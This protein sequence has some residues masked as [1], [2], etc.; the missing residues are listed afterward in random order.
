METHRTAS[1]TAPKRRAQNSWEGLLFFASLNWYIENA[2]KNLFTWFL[3]LFENGGMQGKTKFVYLLTIIDAYCK[4]IR[5]FHTSMEFPP[6][7]IPPICIVPI[8]SSTLTYLPAKVKLPSLV[9]LFLV[10]KVSSRLTENLAKFKYSEKEKTLTLSCPCCVIYLW[11]SKTTGRSTAS[12]CPIKFII[13]NIQ[14]VDPS[15]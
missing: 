7:T 2:I 4:F 1:V 6:L 12:P 3:F 13:H 8:T 5:A 15:T 11:A 10:C 9:S 14:R